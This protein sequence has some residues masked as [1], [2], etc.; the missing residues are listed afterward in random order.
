M[1]T[2]KPKLTQGFCNQVQGVGGKV[3]YPDHE[4][5]GLELR[6]TAAGAKAFVVRYRKPNRKQTEM[7]LGKVG[8]M[9][10]AEARQRAREAL[11]EVAGGS[12]P[13]ESKKTAQRV[14]MELTEGTVA[15]V[16][17][18]WTTS[19]KYLDL[20]ENTRRGYQVHLDKRIIPKLGHV[21]IKEIT[22]ADVSK[23]LDVL[24]KEQGNAVSNGT[25]TALSALFTFALERDLAQGNPVRDVTPMQRN[26]IKDRVLSAEELKALW[27]RTDDVIERELTGVNM[28][29]ALAFAVR[30]LM[31]IPARVSEVIGMRWDEIDF[32]EALLTVPLDRMKG[33]KS[34]EVPLAEAA[35]KTLAD[36][37]EVKASQSVWV[38]PKKDM[39]GPMSRDVVG[40]ACRR[41]AGEMGWKNF[42]PHDLRRTFATNLAGKTPTEIIERVL[43]HNVG[44][45]K[46]IVYYDHHTYRE[47]KRRA[48][49]A[50]E[51][52]LMEIV[53]VTDAS[54]DN[55]VKLSDRANGG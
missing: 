6:V 46:A 31:L 16:A 55:I 47:E 17:E 5:K 45:G 51:G 11:V 20:R 50:W 24:A 22:R 38:F 3:R 15:K 49:E 54:E 14:A 23:F 4:V 8:V 52:I 41:F 2:D 1:T 27:A 48:L 44:G 7:T 10:L 40:K 26:K 35:L 18:K 36:W 53:G 34:H 32:D 21:P 42:G 19:T 30:L 9:T 28:T 39:S 37:R 43:G 25:R 29:L 13:A 33:K 12:D